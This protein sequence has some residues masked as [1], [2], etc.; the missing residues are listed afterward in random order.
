MLSDFGTEVPGELCMSNHLPMASIQSI[1]TLH[2]AGHSNREIARILGIDRG[3]VNKYVQRLR[4]AEA[5]ASLPDAA[6][7]DCQNRP[8]LHIR[9]TG[10][11]MSGCL[12]G[13]PGRTGPKSLCEQ[14]CE[15]ITSKLDQGLSSVR[16]HQDLRSEHSFPG[17]YHSVRRFIEHLG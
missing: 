4:A 2:R 9:L 11:E 17:S 7:A 5:P 16:I 8:N 6:T 3:A 13:F 1:E 15:V 14:Y 10:E 12:P